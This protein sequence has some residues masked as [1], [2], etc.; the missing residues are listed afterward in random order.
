MSSSNVFGLKL[1]SPDQKRN[2]T[3]IAKTTSS[4]QAR[5]KN[6]ASETYVVDS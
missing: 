4:S 5:L 1:V 2:R 6:R 3:E